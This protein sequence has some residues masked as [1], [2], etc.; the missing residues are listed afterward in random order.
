MVVLRHRPSLLPILSAYVHG[1][2]NAE[3][4]A[5]NNLPRQ[6][7]NKNKMSSLLRF[8][9]YFSDYLIGQLYIQLRYIAL[10]KI[11]VYDRYYFDFINDPERSNIRLSN[12]FTGLLYNALLKP[13]YNFFLYANPDVILERK[14]ELEAE[15]IVE[16]TNKYIKLFNKLSTTQDQKY[17]SI[18]NISLEKTINQMVSQISFQL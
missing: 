16:L 4:I 3:S 9:Y 10:G 12:K 7:T 18:N 1:K 14:K 13:T 2:V 15:T 11:V 8:A 6:G 17:V 5:A